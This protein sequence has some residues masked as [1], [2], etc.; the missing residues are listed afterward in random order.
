MIKLPF[1]KF[2][3][4]RRN[5]LT[6]RRI[7]YTLS[8]QMR[9]PV[10]LP[11]L[12][13]S[14]INYPDSSK[15]EDDRD[16]KEKICTNLTNT[17]D[18]IIVDNEVSNCIYITA[19]KKMINDDYDINKPLENKLPNPN[20]ANF[21]QIFNEKIKICNC[22]FNF[23]NAQKQINGKRSK[24][25]ALIEI[26]DFLSRKGDAQLLTS[27]QKDLIMDMISK[28][29]FE[30]DPFI[31][32]IKVYAT[33]PKL[34]FIER[35]W[36]HLSHI[37]KILN[38][39][40]LLFPEKFNI[41]HV[42]KAIRLMNIP[43]VNER[44]NLATFLKNYTKVHYDQISEIFKLLKTAITNVMGDIYTPYCVDPIISFITQIFLSNGTKFC[45]QM[46][47]T[48][49]LPLFKHHYLFHYF[50]KLINLII[51]IVKDKPS[52]QINVIQYIIK[53]FPRQNGS[54]QPLFLSAMIEIIQMMNYDNLNS[55][56]Y[57]LINFIASNLNSPNSKL[58]ETVL[59]LLMKQNMRPIIC[60]NYEFAMMTLYE[61]LKYTSS[62]YWE[63]N[64]KEQS[65][66]AL[67]MLM[68]ANLQ[69][70]ANKMMSDFIL[71]SELPTD[72]LAACEM[73]IHGKIDSQEVAL[74]WGLISRSAA[75]KDSTI[76]L[77]KT[78]MNIQFQFNR[79]NN[80]KVNNDEKNAND[81]NSKMER[82]GLIKSKLSYN[83]INQCKNPLKTNF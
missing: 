3:T 46:L 56:S 47:Y 22:I 71:A 44:E 21:S 38:Q 74:T 25:N 76:D 12:V 77:T 2:A 8:A 13:S 50:T 31:S 58:T 37:Y 1:Q 20:D 14:T 10:V 61:H 62:F 65:K 57:Q 34:S 81:E 69:F 43:D 7:P 32:H 4:K 35:S 80:K 75:K 17:K 28:N 15:A 39:F 33:I 6:V 73:K 54:K 24:L 18:E 36:E 40:V 45:T 16:V 27:K 51:E 9:N 41:V 70:Q 72:S 42:E 53:H 79:G 78:L 60:S 83:N 29:I 52:D 11:K 19:N 5:S 26:H 67:S 49:L 68:N 64:V 55:I 48:Y 82:K 23:N 30:Q 66:S 63:R 59:S